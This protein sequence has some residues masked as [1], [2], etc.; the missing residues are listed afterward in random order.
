MTQSPT[1]MYRHLLRRDLC[2]FI[3]RAY[4]ELYPADPYLSNWHIELIAS[5]LEEV[6][7]GRCKRLIINVGPK[8]LPGLVG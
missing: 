4:L 6:R 2:A 5:K 8:L 1:R 7:T 3:Q